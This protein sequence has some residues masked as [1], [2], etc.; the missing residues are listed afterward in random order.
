LYE[1]QPL[2]LVTDHGARESD[3]EALAR[4]VAEKVFDAT[5]ITIEREVVTLD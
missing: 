5:G 3:V 2:V 4:A 1:N